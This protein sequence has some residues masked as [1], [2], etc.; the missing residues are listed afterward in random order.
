MS[1]ENRPFP[2]LP[3]AASISDILVV[4]SGNM[5]RSPMAAAILRA[6]LQD[7]GVRGIRVH[8]AGTIAASGGSASVDSINVCAQYGLDISYHRTTTLNAEL[9]RQAGLILV[10]EQKHKERVI[11]LLPEAA[12]K[13]FLLSEFADGALRDKNLPDPIGTSPVFYEQ[14]FDMMQP[15]IDNFVRLLA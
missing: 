8:S 12:H 4:C 5:C 10:M 7:A 14:L 15:M 13:T 2:Q 6:A 11:D 9:V 1:K 3:P